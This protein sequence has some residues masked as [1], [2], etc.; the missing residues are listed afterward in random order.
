MKAIYIGKWFLTI[1]IACARFCLAFDFIAV[2]GHV[3]VLEVEISVFS[4]KRKHI[5][6]LTLW[7]AL[8]QIVLRDFT[9]YTVPMR[10]RGGTNGA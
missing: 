5:L 1:I 8:K 6:L 3:D 10:S 2:G 9:R 7:H 4:Y